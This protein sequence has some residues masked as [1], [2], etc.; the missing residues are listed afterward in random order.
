MLKF[1]KNSK[2]RLHY[3][4]PRSAQALCDTKHDILGIPFDFIGYNDVLKTIEHWR[5][6]GRTE[7]ITFTP[8]YSV[9]LSSRD[10]EMYAA[11][12]Q[13]GLVLPDGVG[14]ILAARIL[15][16]KNSGRVTGP[17]L[18]LKACDWGHKHKYRHFFYG[19][20]DG[21]ADALAAR[22]S[23][24][25]PGLQVAGT[26][27]PPFEP[28]SEKESQAI[29]EEI[30]ATNPDIVW[31][32]L[33]TQKQETWMAKHLGK[34][35]ATAMIGVG[36][37]FDFHSGKIKWAPAQIRRIGLEWA[38]RLAKE[39]KRLWRRNLEA[40]I[41]VFKVI[42]QRLRTPKHSL[43]FQGRIQAEKNIHG[44]R[45]RSEK[46]TSFRDAFSVDVED[47]Y[48]ILDSPAVPNIEQ[49][50]S[51]ESRVEHN[52][53]RIL[54]LLHDHGVRAT[55]FWLGWIAE[56]HKSLLKRCSDAGH[57]IASHGYG[58][59]L[60]F[61]VGRRAFA[62]DI[63]LGKAVLEDIIGE[64]VLGFR[65]AGFSTADDTPWIFEEIRAAGHSYDSSVFPII[66][67][68]GGMMQSRLEP[69]IVNTN[70]GN[71]VE[72]PQ[73]VVKVFGKGISLFGGGYLRL[74]PKW[75]IKWGINRLHKTNRPLIV[76]I[77][78]REI[79]PN[80]PRL[81]LSMIRYFRSYYNL[82]S[83]MPKLRWLCE[84]YNFVPMGE[85]VNEFLAAMPLLEAGQHQGPGST[86]RGSR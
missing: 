10:A 41:F 65:A 82:E 36:A 24:M 46:D 51:L 28:L 85:L 31:V 16:Y 39:P 80:H 48:H 14:I 40:P 83:T 64:E 69:Y 25:Y 22:L 43:L 15:N 81:P 7:Y 59:V 58:H 60:A 45:Y 52:I 27:S 76:Y 2:H 18:L 26:Y 71:L 77:H 37:A 42:C 5:Q 78:P 20:A 79:D 9:L 23:Q 11:T 53:D 56:R 66:R 55:F 21:V 8:P 38:Y 19:G 63:W 72:I 54:E 47:W 29:I 73:S 44:H 84:N 70:V 75:S 33:G 6:T 13:A 3:S 49:W 62:K 61:K 68:H 30:N 57:E 74:S 67:D 35:K 4:K 12:N 17:N 1:M 50:A 32:G 86:R 34:I